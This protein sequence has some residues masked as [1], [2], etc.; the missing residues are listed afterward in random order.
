MSMVV[1]SD[2]AKRQIS[3]LYGTLGFVDP[4]FALLRFEL[5]RALSTFAGIQLRTG[6]AA[7]VLRLKVEYY[8]C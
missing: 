3:E 5:G 7:T 2:A 4:I 1:A 8:V 6:G